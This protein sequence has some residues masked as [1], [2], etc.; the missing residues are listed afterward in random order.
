MFAHYWLNP[1]VGVKL[2]AS[3]VGFAGCGG[4]RDIEGGRVHDCADGGL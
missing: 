3:Q 2:G 4:A 1:G